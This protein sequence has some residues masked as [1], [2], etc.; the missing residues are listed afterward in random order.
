MSEFQIGPHMTFSLQEG[1]RME[2]GLFSPTAKIEAQERRDRLMLK[3]R[4]SEELICDLCSVPIG[5]VTFN[6]WDEGLS[7]VFCKTCKEK[8]AN[9]GK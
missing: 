1:P 7:Y 9:T 3:C 4:A 5:W 6:M 2:D 8:H